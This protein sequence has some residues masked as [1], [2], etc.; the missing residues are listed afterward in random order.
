MVAPHLPQEI[1]EEIIDL[2]AGDKGSLLSCSLVSTGWVDR[3]RYHLLANL[4]LRSLSDLQF[5]SGTGLGRFSHHVRSLDLVQND[6]LKWIVP[7]ALAQVLNDFTSF[8]NV[9]SLALIDLDL[10]LFDQHSLPRYFGHLSERLTSLSVKRSTVNPDTLLFFICMFPGLDDLELDNLSMGKTPI[11]SPCPAVTPRFR[12]KLTLLNIKSNGTSAAAPFIDPP[13]P[14]AFRDVCVKNCRFDTP[15]SLRDL[16][17]ACQETVK[18]VKVAR[19]Y[20]GEFHLR[21]PT[22]DVHVSPKPS[23]SNAP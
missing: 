18:T 15:K 10:T 12:G 23:V 4:K 14:M 7:D 3:S 19:I 20:L 11:S 5:W 2:L 1:V 13:L 16:F 22:A 17:V 6:E 9:Q 8:Y 21:S